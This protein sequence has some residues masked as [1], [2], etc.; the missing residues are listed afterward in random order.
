MIKKHPNDHSMLQRLFRLSKSTIR[1]LNKEYEENHQKNESR[2]LERKNNYEL[3]L[4]AKDLVEKFIKPPTVPVTISKIQNLIHNEL[5]EVYSIYI[6]RKYIK[7]ALKYRFKKGSSRPPKYIS[8]RIQLTKA[9]FCTELL[10]LIFKK[11]IVINIDESSFERSIK[12]HYSWLP[13]GKSCAIINDRLIGKAT[14]ILAT[15]SNSKWFAMAIVGTVDSIKFCI[16]MKFLELIIKSEQDDSIKPPTII[17]DNA[18][19]HT[20]NLTKEIV[21]KLIF[22][23][24]FLVPYWPEIAPVEQAFGIIKSKLRSNDIPKTINFDK[25][26]G[27]RLILNLLASISHASWEKMWIKV[28]QEAKATLVKM[29]EDSNRP[30]QFDYADRRQVI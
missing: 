17:V 24:R 3:S 2:L 30:I 26:E 21:S 16:F 8:R 14:L 6:I 11:E 4:E 13:K 15:W 9:L 7:D 18:K 27:I 1:R 28:I 10:S 25:D 19:T 12:R 22:K 5:G 23:T 29:K 20:S